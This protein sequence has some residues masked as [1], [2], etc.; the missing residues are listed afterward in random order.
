MTYIIQKSE[1]S[2]EISVHV[3]HLKQYVGTNHPASWI[4]N[5]NDPEETEIPSDTEVPESEFQDEDVEP[6][7]MAV[8]DWSRHGKYIHLNFVCKM[9]INRGSH[10]LPV[11]D[12][13]EIY[14]VC[15]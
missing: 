15:S 10:C 9:L 7:V 11:H 3:D 14:I 1:D 5:D 8:V 2:N 6:Q 12:R 4:P 13:R